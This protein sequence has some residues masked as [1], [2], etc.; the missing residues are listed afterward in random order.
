ML[1]LEFPELKHKSLYETMYEEWY[2]ESLESKR[3]ME[4]FGSVG[5][6]FDKLLEKAQADVLGRE[7]F[8]PATLF[9][10]VDADSWKIVWWIQIRHHINHPNL[11]RRWGHIGYGVS[12]SERRKWYA[13]LMLQLA[14]VEV[15]KLWIK[16]VLITCR[17]DNIGSIGVI[18]KCS[19]VLECELLDEKSGEMF[20]RY[21]IEV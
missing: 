10:L 2:Q 4:L 12:P 14:L 7:W 11:I 21:W 17:A 3:P 6:D 1:K 16:K 5:R 9:F 13:T 19:W 8:V 18:E 20:R 15:K